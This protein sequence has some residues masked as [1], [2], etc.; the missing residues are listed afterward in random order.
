MVLFKVAVTGEAKLEEL[1]SLINEH[2]GEW[3]DDDITPLDGKEHSYIELGAWLGSQGL[4]L[5]FMALG[6]ALGLFDLLTP[7]TVFPPGTLPEN[8]MMEMAASGLLTIKVK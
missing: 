8:Q 4:A 2:K 3:T 7:K 6:H 5:Q 1:K